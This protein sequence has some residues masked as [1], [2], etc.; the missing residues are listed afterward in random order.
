MKYV[1]KIEE[2]ALQILQKDKSS[3]DW[4]VSCMPLEHI[5]TDI[6]DRPE[7]QS[8]EVAYVFLSKNGNLS[9]HERNGKF[10][11]VVNTGKDALLPIKDFCR[12]C[13]DRDLTFTTL[14]FEPV[15]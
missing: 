5:V 11:V 15:W 7:E 14:G 8:K 2:A 10:Q 12:I 3:D 6:N 13:E 1:I 4:Q 9:F